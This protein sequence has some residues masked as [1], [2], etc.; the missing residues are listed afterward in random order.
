MTAVC[1]CAAVHEAQ[2]LL[3][4]CAECDAVCCPSCAVEIESH[5]YCRW[6]AL[7]SAPARAA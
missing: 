3:R 1:E 4:G 5:A 6:C 2:F 7:G